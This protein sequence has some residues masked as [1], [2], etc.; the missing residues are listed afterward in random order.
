M[1]A[2]VVVSPES[3]DMG[4]KLTDVGASTVLPPPLKTA[5]CCRSSSARSAGARAFNRASSAGASFTRA[6]C[7][8]CTSR[9]ETD[10]G[11]WTAAVTGCA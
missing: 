11:D 6:A 3:S 10:A 4:R 2:S 1:D 9:A 8:D 7:R 5:S